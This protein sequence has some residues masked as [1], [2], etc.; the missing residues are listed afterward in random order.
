MREKLPFKLGDN[1]R[2]RSNLVAGKDYSGIILLYAMAKHC[3][4]K[5]TT[6]VDVDGMFYL[7]ENGY[8]WTEEMLEKAGG[9]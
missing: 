6:I 7:A 4:G 5:R 2:I 9:N 1:V 8:W 3:L